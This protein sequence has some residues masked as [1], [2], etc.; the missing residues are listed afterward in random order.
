L[1]HVLEF[2][3]LS[4][5][6]SIPQALLSSFFFEP[7]PGEQR[8]MD[9]ETLNRKLLDG[10]VK[11][12]ERQFAQ[13]YT[14]TQKRVFYY[15]FRL[16]KSHET[17][18]DLLMTTYTEVWKLA[19]NFRGDSKVLTWIFG[20]ARNLAM[21][22]IRKNRKLESELGEDLVYPS[23]QFSH[24]EKAEK[25]QILQEALN[26]LSFEHREI[27]DFVFLQGMGYEDIA[28]I[29]HIPVNTVKTRVFYAKEKLRT[30]LT[31]MGIRKDDLL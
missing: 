15:L 29:I 28:Q 1:T 6:L 27:L 3:T 8:P 17:A 13:L 31:R 30:I 25:L 18:E 7:F 21:N 10:V 20:I 11:K 16:T 26:R 14:I 22:E 4:L 19:K 5:N 2:D 9:D 23:D 24:S 12:D